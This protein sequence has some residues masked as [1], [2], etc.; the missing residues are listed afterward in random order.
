MIFPRLFLNQNK[1]LKDAFAGQ[2]KS[3]CLNATL[4]EFRHN[5]N[6]RRDPEVDCFPAAFLK[7]KHR[8]GRQDQNKRYH[9]GRLMAFLT[10]S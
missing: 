5:L 1:I 7:P 4:W 6:T 10:M 3:D 8:P 9:I 2:I